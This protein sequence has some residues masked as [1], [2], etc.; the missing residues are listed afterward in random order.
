VVGQPTPE[1]MTPSEAA[2]AGLC[3]GCLGEGWTFNIIAGE[4]M[5]CSMCVG[6]GT[7]DAMWEHASGAYLADDEIIPPE[8]GGFEGC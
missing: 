1:E 5:P 3:P 4:T 2:K 7:I 8:S 6:V